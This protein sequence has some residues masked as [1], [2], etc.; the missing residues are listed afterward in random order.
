[1][2]ASRVGQAWLG[3]L[4]LSATIPCRATQMLT[5]VKCGSRGACDAGGDARVDGGHEAVEDSFTWT[6]AGTGR[7]QPQPGAEQDLVVA[8]VLEAEA[9]VGVAAGA[10]PSGGVGA[11]LHGAGQGV[12]DP[13]LIT[14]SSYG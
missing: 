4:V 14:I 8:R 12:N 10:E 5:A 1:M 3:R 13:K 7:I 9:A 6:V 2:S 11:A